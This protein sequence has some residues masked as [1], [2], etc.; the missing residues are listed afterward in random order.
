MAKAESIGAVRD[1]LIAQLKNRGADPL[2]G[3]IAS[4]EEAQRFYRSLP[5]AEIRDEGIWIE[6]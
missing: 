3:L 6:L 5:C 1:S 2:I 4:N